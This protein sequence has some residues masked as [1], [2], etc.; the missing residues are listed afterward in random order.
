MTTPASHSAD[1]WTLIDRER[2]GD[3]LIKRLCVAAWTATFALA[4]VVAIAVGASVV[5]MLR[6]AALGGTTL[7]G[8]VGAAMPLIGML[9][10][11]SLLAAALTTVGVFMRQRA[12]SLAEIQL[13]L[14]ALEDMLAST[15]DRER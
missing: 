14:A 4:L 10:T 8:V 13:R 2:R 11:L 3:R 7:M 12:A 5:Q 1:A 15:R 9:W 6:I